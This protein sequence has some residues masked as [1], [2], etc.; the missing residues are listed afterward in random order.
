VRLIKSRP[1]EEQEGELKKLRARP[2]GDTADEEQDAVPFRSEVDFRLQMRAKKGRPELLELGLERSSSFRTA[3]GLLVS[4]QC[5]P[6]C[7]CSTQNSSYPCPPEWDYVV[8]QLPT[9]YETFEVAIV[10]PTTGFVPVADLGDAELTDAFA[11]HQAGLKG[12][13][14]IYNFVPVKTVQRLLEFLNE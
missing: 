10:D 14:C 5:G 7:R 11:K 1:P 4:V 12:P 6:F 3:G 8:Q 2:H 9:E 13:D